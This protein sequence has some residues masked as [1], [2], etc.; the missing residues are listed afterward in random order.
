M[1]LFFF[2]SLL[3][4]RENEHKFKCAFQFFVFVCFFS[5]YFFLLLRYTFECVCCLHLHARLNA[6]HVSGCCYWQCCRRICV[7]VSSQK[8]GQLCELKTMAISDSLCWNFGLADA[9]ISAMNESRNLICCFIISFCIVYLI[10]F[11]AFNSRFPRDPYMHQ[12][13]WFIREQKIYSAIT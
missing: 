1:L 12:D 8:W 7:C 11:I 5:L 9:L 4:L 13:D 6:L 3:F 2:F 10:I